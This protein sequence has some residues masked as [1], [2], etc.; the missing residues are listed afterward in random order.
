MFISRQIEHRENK[1]SHYA[2]HQ[3]QRGGLNGR[4]RQPSQP[5]YK[6]HER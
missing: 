6:E 5:T 2:T 4:Y 3:G 1:F